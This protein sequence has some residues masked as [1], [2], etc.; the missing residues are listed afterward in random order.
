[1]LEFFLKHVWEFSFGGVAVLIVLYIWLCASKILNLNKTIENIIKTQDIKDECKKNER[2]DSVWKNFEKTLTKASEKVYST[3]DAAE[4]FNPQNLTSGMNMTF[5]QSYGGIF[6]GLGILGTFAGLTF[7]LSKVDMMSGDVETLKDGIAQLL[8]GVETAF[9]TSLVGIGA[10][11][12]YSSFHYYLMKNF[13]SKVNALAK[14]LDEKFPRRSVE[15]L[16]VENGKE[17]KNHTIELKNIGAQAKIENSWLEK[18]YSESQGQTT[19]L[20]NIAADIG[21]QRIILKNIGEDVAR[22]IYD[23]LDERMNAAVETLCDKLEER[24]LPQVDRICAAIENLGSGGVDKVGEIFT[25]GVGSQMDRFSAALDRFSND[26][27]KKLNTANKIANIMNEQLLE[28]LQALDETLRRNAQAVATERNETLNQFLTSLNGLTDTL[29]KVSEKIKMNG[30]T[31][32]K[33]I[34]AASEQ[35]LSTLASLNKTLEDLAKK[36]KSQQEGNLNSF[37]TLI[38]KLISNLNEF[39]IKQQK[40]LDAMAKSNYVQIS[41]AVKAFREVVDNHNETTKKTFAQVQNLLNETELFLDNIDTASDSLKQAAEPVKQST[42]QLSDNLTET[43]TQIKTLATTNQTTRQNLLELSDKIKVF[44][45]NF[46][47][48]SKELETSTNMIKDSLEN[49]NSKMNDGMTKN[50]TEFDK[51]ITDAVGH[52]QGLVEGLTDALED[53]KQIRNRA[54]MINEKTNTANRRRRAG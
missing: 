5:W 12:I 50:L 35:F 1:M 47:G 16:L 20:K 48:I 13:Q 45:D 43:S 9:V 2:L 49:Y 38:N 18:S 31:V 29:N 14:N 34:Q 10:A 54:V 37:E 3:I 40:F 46:N 7:G 39:S 22:A 41:E 19:E 33:Q 15:D 8:S 23:G 4:F 32:N 51:R 26:I 53:L 42:K 24:L 6:T 21:D 28:T 27:D 52:L 36:I 30:E 25:K 17:S 11:L 44:V